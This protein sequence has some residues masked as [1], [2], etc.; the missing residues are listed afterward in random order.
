MDGGLVI[1]HA[2]CLLYTTL[3]TYYNH[4]FLLGY[5]RCIFCVM[6]VYTGVLVSYSPHIRRVESLLGMGFF[7]LLSAIFATP[8]AVCNLA[9]IQETSKGALI[10]ASF[11]A[12]YIPASNGGGSVVDRNP[13]RKILRMKIINF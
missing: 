13:H 5:D 9:C 8:M 10:R 3:L 7:S 6:G 2:R 1:G 11:V 4:L 12:L